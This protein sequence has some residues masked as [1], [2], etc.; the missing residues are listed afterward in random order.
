MTTE[1]SSAN[2]LETDS[3]LIQAELQRLLK[4]KKFSAAGQMSAFLR[5]IVTQTLEGNG[6]RIKAYTVGVDAL[7]K[8][9]SFDAQNDP[10]VRVLA[11]RLRKSLNASYEHDEGL[12]HVRIV[13]KVGTYVP[14]FHKAAPISEVDHQPPTGTHIS[15]SRILTGSTD[16][17]PGSPHAQISNA[18]SPAVNSAQYEQRLKNT[19]ES[20]KPESSGAT[21]RASSWMVGGTLLLIVMGWTASAWHNDSFA[22]CNEAVNMNNAVSQGFAHNGA[23]ESQDKLASQKVQPTLY[24]SAD[25]GDSQHVK[26]MSVLLGSSVVEQGALDV[27][28]V[29]RTNAERRINGIGYWMVIDEIP[30]DSRSTVVVQLLRQDTGAVVMSTTLTLNA[31]EVGFSTENMRWIETLASDISSVDGPLFRDHCA[32]ISLQTT[33]S[34]LQVAEMVPEKL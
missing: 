14:E 12:H 25:S 20:N 17:S 31:A 32:D 6:D 13:L 2:Q 11:L 9:D 34:C 3:A 16:A 18:G 30:L 19:D 29:S 5:Y 21:L 24:M 23:T 33:G 10:S 15:V 8:P 27:V 28:R 7:G 4:Q 22:T 26:Q 1:L